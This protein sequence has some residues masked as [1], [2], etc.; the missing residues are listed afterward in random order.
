MSVRMRIISQPQYA[1]GVVGTLHRHLSVG[2]VVT[3]ASMEPDHRGD[4]TVLRGDSRPHYLIDPACLTPIPD[5]PTLAEQV[6]KLRAGDEVT[7]RW[8]R[9]G[10]TSTETG[11]LYVSTAGYLSLPSSSIVRFRSGEPPYHLAAVVDHTPARPD[12]PGTWGVVEADCDS[13]GIGRRE[14]TRYPPL[15]DRDRAVWRTRRG[16]GGKWADLI[17]P[18]VIRDGIEEQP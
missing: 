9:D 1:S 15:D 2:D 5:E 3:V 4:V 12:E 16:A 6:A 11:V 7:V 10:H 18:V 14:W 13:L 8:E 17:D